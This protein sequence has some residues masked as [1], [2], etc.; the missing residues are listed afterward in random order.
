M[1][2]LQELNQKLLLKIKEMEDENCELKNN[3]GVSTRNTNNFEKENLRLKEQIRKLTA[4]KDEAYTL[5]EEKQNRYDRMIQLYDDVENKS[6]KFIQKNKSL[7]DLLLNLITT[8]HN[9]DKP[10]MGLDRSGNSQTSQ[11]KSK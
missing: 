11:N 5:L 7:N 3:S 1:A 8:Y 9:R 4:E 10:Q 6:E 2:R